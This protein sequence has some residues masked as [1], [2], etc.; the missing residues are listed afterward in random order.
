MRHSCAQLCSANKALPHNP[1]HLLAVIT[2][3]IPTTRD[4]LLGAGSHGLPAGRCRGG[5]RRS[6]RTTTGA[7]S[8][9]AAPAAPAGATTAAL[10]AGQGA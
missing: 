4:L 9:A 8:G 1:A 10:A 5:R 3:A 6:G 2:V 7:G